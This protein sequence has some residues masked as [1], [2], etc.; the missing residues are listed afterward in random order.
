M[1]SLFHAGWHT[2]SIVGATEFTR[3]GVRSFNPQLSAPWAEGCE[4]DT[5]RDEENKGQS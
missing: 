4:N 3:Y 1:H 5:I 2:R